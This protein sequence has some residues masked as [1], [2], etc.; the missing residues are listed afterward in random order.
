LTVDVP[1]FVGI[2][3]VV[4]LVWVPTGCYALTR[5]EICEVVGTLLRT[6]EII[7]AMP[8]PFGKFCDC[9]TKARLILQI[10]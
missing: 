4:E 3:S 7:V 1:G 8:I 2:V 9:S 10:T 6:K 5:G